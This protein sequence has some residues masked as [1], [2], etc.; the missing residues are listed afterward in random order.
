M[1]LLPGF[2]V[3]AFI[4]LMFGCLLRLLRWVGYF[5]GFVELVFLLLPVCWF[6]WVVCLVIAW[7]LWVC[8]LCLILFRV[9]GE[10]V[11]GYCD[12]VRLMVWFMLAGCG[13]VWWRY[14]LVLSFRF[15]VWVSVW[16][17]FVGAAG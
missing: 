9:V 16:I 6:G 10:L 11:V 14:C 3:W 1:L 2:P 17:T 15:V 5:A 8:V 12:L 4:D 13:C 7:V